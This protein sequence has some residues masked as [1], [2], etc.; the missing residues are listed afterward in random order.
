LDIDFNGADI[1][2]LELLH[3]FWFKFSMD[4]DQ[5]D[6]RINSFTSKWQDFRDLLDRQ[7]I[8]A[9]RK[10]DNSD[11]STDVRKLMDNVHKADPDF[12]AALRWSVQ[13]RED[14]HLAITLQALPHPSSKLKRDSK[15]CADE[16]PTIALDS[17]LAHTPF[18]SEGS[19]RGPQPILFSRDPEALTTALTE[20]QTTIHPGIQRITHKLCITRNL[21]VDDAMEYLLNPYLDEP[22]HPYINKAP[23]HPSTT[24]ALHPAPEEHPPGSSQDTQPKKRKQKGTKTPQHSCDNEKFNL[25]N[26]PVQLKDFFKQQLEKQNFKNKILQDECLRLIGNSLAKSTWNRYA[27]SFKIWKT[28][29]SENGKKETHLSENTKIMFICWCSKNTK[30]KSSTISI[31]LSAINHC[32]T[33]LAVDK[34]GETLRAAVVKG[35]KNSQSKHTRKIKKPCKPV[36]VHML[37]KFRKLSCK[38]GGKRCYAEMCV[39]CGHGCILG[40]F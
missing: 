27:A 20:D 9:F 33:L 10:N 30:L 17:F 39:G 14:D 24:A 35:L 26:I 2:K 31:Y 23:L 40:L 4:P 29:C 38:G 3:A 11:A 28:F 13:A 32:L 18:T 8:T 25:N 19:C 36:T 16:C 1:F 12:G 22:R 37:K 6:I 15:L 21:D 7:F 5:M 34:G